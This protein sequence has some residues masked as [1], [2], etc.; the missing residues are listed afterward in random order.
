MSCSQAELS[1][2]MHSSLVWYFS[3]TI[4][5]ATS[6]DFRENQVTPGLF[7]RLKISRP[8]TLPGKSGGTAHVS[9][10]IYS[11]LL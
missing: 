11:S 9:A 5:V 3:A 1:A 10:F 6:F 7:S 8:Q 2:I 4:G